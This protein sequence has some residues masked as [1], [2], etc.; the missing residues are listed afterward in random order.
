MLNHD[1]LIVA[2]DIVLRVG[3]DDFQVVQT[4]GNV[5]VVQGLVFYLPKFLA[6]NQ[7][8]IGSINAYLNVFN[9]CA[10]LHLELS[11][12]RIRINVDGYISNRSST[13]GGV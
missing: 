6:F 9:R 4:F 1:F 13:G 7:A 3:G 2:K 5:A 10:Q 12:A 11:T 8:A